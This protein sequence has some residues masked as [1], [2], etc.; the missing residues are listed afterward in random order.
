MDYEKTVTVV[1]KL[2]NI[3]LAPQLETTII[4]EFKELVSPFNSWIYPV[5]SIS[6]PFNTLSKPHKVWFS[7]QG[8]SMQFLSCL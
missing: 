5:H 4:Q 8:F 3:I 1:V 6:C 7:E 2:K